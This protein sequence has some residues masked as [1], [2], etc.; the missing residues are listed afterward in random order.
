[1]SIQETQDRDCDLP[2][3]ASDL[4]SWIDQNTADVGARY[5]QYLSERKSGAPRAY[6]KT[7]SHA[8]HFLK[9]VAPTKTVDGAWLYGLVKHW[10]DAR[11]GSLIRIYLE[12]LGSGSPDKNHVVLYKKLLSAQGCDKWTNLSD[13][14]F[15]QG[16]IQ[17]SLAH[18]SDQFLPEIIGFN[19]GYEQLPLHLLIT[20]YELNELG[21]DP[22]YFTL[23]VTVDNADTGHARNA[24]AGLREAWPVV[25]DEARFYQRVMNGYKLNMLGASTNS[26]IQDFDLEEELITIFKE[27]SVAGNQVHSDYCRVAGRTINDWLRIAEDIPAFMAALEKAGWIKR[28]QDPEES[29]FWKLL[30]GDRAEMFGVFSPYELQVIYD[31]IKGDASETDTGSSPKKTLTF[32][33][34]QR[35]HATLER[36]Q[37][38]DGEVVPAAPLPQVVNTLGETH[39]NDFNAEVRR[40]DAALNKTASR[41]EAMNLLGTLISPAHHHTVVGLKATRLFARMFS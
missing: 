3:S 36:R 23:H 19:L 2:A 16:L 17:L 28:N 8:L 41:E 15:V 11:F 1:M 20:A 22:Y 10:N 26:I 25:G 14:H 6:F 40:L 33:A 21:I 29:R 5:Q 32:K 31:W 12:E 9:A 35:L 7:K 4:E 24:L 39:A 30:Q 37:S 38:A 34:R 18:H 13:T 27:K